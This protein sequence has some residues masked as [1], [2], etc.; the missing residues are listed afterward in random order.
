MRDLRPHR[1]LGA[2]AVIAA[3]LVAG[4]G[5]FASPALAG[6]VTAATGPVSTKPAAGTPH[7]LKTKTE[8]V[9]RQLVQCGDMMYAVGRFWGISQGSKTYGRNN[10]FSF[11]ATAPYTVS[12]WNPDVKGEVNSIAFTSGNGCADA[13]LGGSF[14]SVHDTPAADIAEVSTSTGALV[15]SF[16]HDANGQVHTLLGYQDHL[17]VGGAFTTINGSNHYRYVSLNPTTGD[18]DGFIN[19]HVAGNVTGGA[20]LIYNQQLS[21]TGNL[22]LVEGNFLSVGGQP[23]QQI[24][25]ANLNTDPATI[26]GWT[27][28][29]FSESCFKTHPL[30]VHDAAWSPDDSTVYIA[31]TGYHLASWVRGTYPLTGLCDVA[32]AFPASQESVSPTWINY[33]GCY[34]LYGIAA[35]TST[36]YVAGH[37][38]Y[39]SNPDGCKSA[40]PGA[41]TDQGFAG[42]QAS[43]GATELNS[44][45][46]ARYSSSRANAGDMLIT[47]GGLW[48]ASSNRFGSNRCDGVSDLA[49][50][51]YLP[52]S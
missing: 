40:G 30:Y 5:G 14:S 12:K 48:I 11:S 19:L 35:D 34:S 4:A 37:P 3:A 36:V 22:V 27:S 39:S 1:L 44:A 43:N 9:I 46:R 51:C 50:I 31:S 38:K 49:G 15:T 10:V 25:M 24:F 18:D 20:G 13:Y 41:I 16:G 2:A 42:L 21:H 33:T 52:Y 29:E 23:R 7:L 6:P 28:S 32:A 17:L 47:S 26:T 8:E 45:G